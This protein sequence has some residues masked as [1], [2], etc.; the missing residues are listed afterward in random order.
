L[1][2]VN[3]RRK[4]GNRDAEKQ[5]PAGDARLALN[6]R[7]K[8]GAVTECGSQVASSAC[9]T[10]RLALVAIVFAFWGV[11]GNTQEL[12]PRAYW[13]APNGTRVGVVGY[14]YT[15][16]SITF[17]PS[18]PIYEAET[19]VNSALLAYLQT[20]SLFGRSSN[21][22]VK[23]PYAWG[24]TEGLIGTEPANREFSNFADLSVT[25]A[26][27]LIGAPSMDVKEF[28]E[29]RADPRPIFGISVE[30]IVPTGDYS[31]DR[32][33]NT[34]ANRWAIKPEF[35]F[36]YPLTSKLLLEIESGVWFYGD[37]DDFVVGKKEQDPIITFETHLIRRFSPGF[38]MSLDWTY[39]T[40]GKQTIGGDQLSDTQSNSRLGGTIVKPLSRRQVVKLGYAAG[41]RTRF[42]TD[43]DQLLLSYQVLL[44]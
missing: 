23:L 6:I 14:A 25:V 39:Y 31:G 5:E 43:F 24:K 29:F 20:F 21:V 17:D 40:G 8:Y 34:G 1:K 22:L 3:W 41:V 9:R 16:G 33:I 15:D 35:G 27:N 4:R 38:W 30:V 32:L 7:K 12:T 19:H 11:A 37:D 2:G 18:I 26:M 42:G 44:N 36:M 10:L 13:P 28:Q